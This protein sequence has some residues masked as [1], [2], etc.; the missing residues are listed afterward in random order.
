M[1]RPGP[2][3]PDTSSASPRTTTGSASPI[4]A[5]AALDLTE[6]AWLAAAIRKAVAQVQGGTGRPPIEVPAAG[7]AGEPG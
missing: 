2:S 4:A 7:R 1:A 5:G 3:R 6:A